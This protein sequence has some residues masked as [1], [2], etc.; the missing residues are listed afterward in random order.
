MKVELEKSYRLLR[1]LNKPRHKMIR[2]PLAFLAGVGVLTVGAP[3]SVA[4]D[5]MQLAARSNGLKIVVRRA[6]W[7][8]HTGWVP[9]AICSDFFFDISEKMSEKASHDLL[10]WLETNT[11]IS[12][13]ERHVWQA[14]LHGGVLENRV[15]QPMNGVDARKEKASR[16]LLLTPQDS[17]WDTD[18][19][20][21]GS[22]NAALEAITVM[23]A[24]PSA[25]TRP[26]HT[27]QK[28][29]ESF[30]KAD[31]Y[32][33]ISDYR[34]LMESIK[35][36]WYV[37]SGTL[38]GAVREKDFLGH[39][40]DIDIGIDEDVFD[41]QVL[42]DA[43]AASVNTWFIKSESY[44]TFRE[45]ESK[46]KVRYSQLE[47]PILVKLVH[48]SG[49]VADLFVHVRDGNILWH[50]SAIHRWD[51]SSFTLAEYPLGDETVHGASDADRYLTENYGDWRT[52]VTSFDCSIDPPNIRYS[53]TAR[54]V[55]YLSKVIYRY[56]L[57]GENERARVYLNALVSD[58]MI[59]STHNGYR[60][61]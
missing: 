60:Y 41:I 8:V 13:F 16:E 46:D 38:L 3:M 50:G 22:V 2:Y 55:T 61:Q 43:V 17:L 19:A 9:V 31:A 49:L 39:D 36:P 57:D 33:T 14:D 54:S 26:T 34:S 45:V 10:A 15:S 28:A 51:N 58:G 30:D 27:F 25:D 53:R 20:F 6:I 21:V 23:L 11:R 47:Q 35:W 5:S 18:Q 52:P 56:L 37:I 12:D 24:T 48:C 40:Y 29:G 59:V 1:F 4:K 44:C 32:Q 42:R 7:F